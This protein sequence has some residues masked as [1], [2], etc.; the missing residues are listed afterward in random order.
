M[1][2]R[3]FFFLGQFLASLILPLWLVLGWGIFG[4]GG[5]AFI[6]VL[7][8]AGVL[9][10]AMVVIT[11]LI[12]IRPDVR[13]ERAYQWPDI[14]FLAALDAAV[15]A[16][17]FYGSAA[18]ILGGL[19][20]V[21]VIAGFWFSLW[22]LFTITTRTVSEQVASAQEKLAQAASGQPVDMGELTVIE[23]EEGGRRGS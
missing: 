15:I 12:H 21:L 7:I 6:I 10:L 4:G 1:S 22:R 5:W 16:L 23:V 11:A 3:R 19:V 13:M 8:A 14:G 18:N 20:A 2:I 9:A 17:G